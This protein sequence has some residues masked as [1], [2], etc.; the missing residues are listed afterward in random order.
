MVGHGAFTTKNSHEHHALDSAHA[1]DIDSGPIA[2]PGADGANITEATESIF[3]FS[4]ATPTTSTPCLPPELHQL[5]VYAL[6]RSC[7]IRRQIAAKL[8]EQCHRPASGVQ[9]QAVREG[10]IAL[11]REGEK[12][13]CREVRDHVSRFSL[14]SK[15]YRRHVLFA[16][17]ESLKRMPMDINTFRDFCA[18]S[19]AC[20]YDHMTDIV[21]ELLPRNDFITPPSLINNGKPPNA[22]DRVTQDMRNIPRRLFHLRPSEVIR[23]PWGHTTDAH[24]V[25]MDLDRTVRS[26]LIFQWIA[27]VPLLP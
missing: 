17:R 8:L 13:I 11:M 19:T 21:L 26:A 12:A 2:S 22:R 5:I 16:E 3:T 27:H 25:L 14:V 10:A 1:M 9:D 20:Q 23:R 24:T 15:D 4:T 6:L 7:T 18:K